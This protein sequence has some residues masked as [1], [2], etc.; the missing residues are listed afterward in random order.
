MIYYYMDM[1]FD[2]KETAENTFGSIKMSM[3]GRDRR[4]T[5][6]DGGDMRLRK[7]VF[8]SQD[9]SKLA[10]ITNAIDGSEARAIDTGITYVLCSG[11]WRKYSTANSGGSGEDNSEWSDIDDE[12]SNQDNG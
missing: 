1:P 6:P 9:L 7:Y 2:S 3:R 10:N 12:P 8:L 5:S 11:E 4:G